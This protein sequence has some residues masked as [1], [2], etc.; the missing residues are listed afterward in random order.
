MTFLQAVALCGAIVLVGFAFA[1][2]VVILAPS[3]I[4]RVFTRGD[5]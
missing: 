2:T 5:K 1:T 4:E 3:I